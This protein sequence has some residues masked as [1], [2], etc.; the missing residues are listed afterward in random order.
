MKSPSF[1]ASQKALNNITYHPKVIYAP[2]L[3][4][5]QITGIDVH[6]I[7]PIVISVCIFY[8]CLGGMKAV[9]WSDLIQAGFMYGV[10]LLIIVK[11]TAKAGG[12]SIVFEKSFEGKRIEAP[13]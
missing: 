5:N 10:M 9:V 11:G 13:E 7:S 3:A 8:T 12:L 2:A 4:F 1:V 6:T